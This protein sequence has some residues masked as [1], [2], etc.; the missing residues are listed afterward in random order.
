MYSQEDKQLMLSL[1]KVASPASGQID[2]IIMLY[3]R[4]I[5]PNHPYTNDGCSGCSPKFSKLFNEL[6]DWMSQNLDKFE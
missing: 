2:Q 3:K 5:N 6:R 4:Y 1:F